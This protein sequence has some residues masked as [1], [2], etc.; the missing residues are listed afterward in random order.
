MKK[1]GFT[2]TGASAVLYHQNKEVQTAQLGLG[3]RAE[4]YDDELAGLLINWCKWRKSKPNHKA[5]P[6]LCW[7]LGSISSYIQPEQRSRPTLLI[8]KT[9]QIRRPG[10]RQPAIDLV[11]PQSQGYSRQRESWQTHKGCHNP[12]RKRTNNHLMIKQPSVVPN[13]WQPEHGKNNGKRWKLRDR[14]QATTKPKRDEEV[15][16]Q[17]KGSFRSSNTM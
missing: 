7:Q 10:P 13:L 8:P 4:V 12:G 15:S 16:K 1:N 14:Q 3:G 17:P 5:P 9:M 2:R 11:V 6:L